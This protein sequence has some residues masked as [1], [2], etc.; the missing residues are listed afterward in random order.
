MIRRLQKILSKEYLGVIW[1]TEI[2]IE[3]RPYPF[4]CLD[5]FLDGLMSSF[6]SDG[7]NSGNKN[8]MFSNSYGHPFFIVHVQEKDPDKKKSLKEII[9]L[10]ETKRGPFNRILI[11]GNKGRDLHSF[12]DSHFKK[13]TFDFLD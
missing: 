12:M 4:F 11:I 6:L 13:F 1:E 2:P 3:Q 5:Y 9:D 8:L 10:F 7:K